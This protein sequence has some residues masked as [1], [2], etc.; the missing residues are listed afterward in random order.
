MRKIY[1]IIFLLS[2]TSSAFSQ[3]LN[4]NWKRDLQASL[5]KF[6]QCTQTTPEKYQCSGFIGESIA[7]VYKTNAFFSEKLSRYLHINEISKSS[8]EDG[9]WKPL[10]YAY[11]QKALEEAQKQANASH[12]VIAVYVTAS[13]IGHIAV[14]LPGKLQFSGSWGFNVPNAASFVFN[15]SEKSFV[16]KGLSYAFSKNMIKDVILY[17]RK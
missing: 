1:A 10:G 4:E 15:D 8:L 6:R 3:G 14:I 2:V 11:D 13:G 5:E 16:D 17:A 7:D 9:P 12:A